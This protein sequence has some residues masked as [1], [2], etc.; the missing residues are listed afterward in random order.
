[1]WKKILVILCLYFVVAFT[2]SNLMKHCS[3]DAATSG[4]NYC[5]YPW[6]QG[7]KTQGPL[8]AIPIT[9][10]IVYVW[11]QFQKRK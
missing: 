2:G 11:G 1:M 10:L 9:I 3:D 6:N 4:S 7:Y 5:G 8:I